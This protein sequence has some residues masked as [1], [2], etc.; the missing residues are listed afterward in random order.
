MSSLFLACIDERI[1]IQVANASL[2]VLM[3]QKQQQE[4]F[5]A[6][7][8][9]EQQVMEKERHEKEKLQLI[10]NKNKNEQ[11]KLSIQFK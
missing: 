6:A 2:Q 1:A 4:M 8:L 5:E 9:H 7:Q 11:S 3:A 10:K